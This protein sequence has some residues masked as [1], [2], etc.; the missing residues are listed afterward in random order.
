MTIQYRNNSQS[1][2]WATVAPINYEVVSE[3]NH[4]SEFAKVNRELGWQKY[5]RSAEAN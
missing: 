5:R 3:A 2:E 1:T 4:W